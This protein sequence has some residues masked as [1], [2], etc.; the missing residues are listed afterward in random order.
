MWLG[1]QIG[2]TQ[3]PPLGVVADP[4]GADGNL[5][6]PHPCWDSTSVTHPGVFIGQVHSQSP[7]SDL[8]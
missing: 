1:Q 2:L 3:Q 6:R 8:K 5:S 7:T 4:R